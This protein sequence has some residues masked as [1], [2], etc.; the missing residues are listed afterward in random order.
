MKD[1]AFVPELGV[2]DVGQHVAF[3]VNYLGCDLIESVQDETTGIV[4]WAEVGH[5]GARLMFQ[6]LGSLAAELPSLS[7]RMSEKTFAVVL[8]I[9]GIEKAEE[10]RSRLE[11]NGVAILTGPVR[12][13]YGSYEFSL[14]DPDGYTI[15]VAGR[16]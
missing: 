5:D 3:Y 12:T 9:G 10:L 4:V 15:V 1:N 16:D 11:S 7:G 14:V 6:E 13:E 2:R 8:R